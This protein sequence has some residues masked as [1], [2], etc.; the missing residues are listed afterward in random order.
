M[1][2]ASK[3]WEDLLDKDSDLLAGI[4]DHGF[5]KPSKI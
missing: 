2:S 3:T 5:I 1:I 4:K